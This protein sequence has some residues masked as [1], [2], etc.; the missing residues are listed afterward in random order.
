MFV[1]EVSS[2]MGNVCHLCKL[3]GYI[4]KFM[5]NKGGRAKTDYR[6]K[7]IMHQKIKSGCYN[8]CSSQTAHL[9]TLRSYM[10]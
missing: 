6:K 8:S 3:S 2:S 9:L 10:P 4:I 7:L 5:F 1:L